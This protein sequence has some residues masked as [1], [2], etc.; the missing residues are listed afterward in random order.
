MYHY[1][2][3]KSA[4]SILQTGVLKQSNID[5]PAD[6]ARYGEGVYVTKMGPNEHSMKSIAENNWDDGKLPQQK[7]K[8]GKMDVAFKLELPSKSV[9]KPQSK[10]DI[11]INHGD[12]KKEQISDVLVRK[13]DTYTS[14]KKKAG[15]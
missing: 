6:D 3:R 1:T 14:I 12:I 2:D 9:S 7:I 15:E 4:K 11:Y 5:G 13:K 10:R 8:E